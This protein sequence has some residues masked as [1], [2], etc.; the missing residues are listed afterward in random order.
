MSRLIITIIL[1]LVL[2]LPDSASSLTFI[3]GPV[4][5]G[6]WAQTWQ[7]SIPPTQIDRIE[8]FIVAGTADFEAPGLRNFSNG[9]V[10]GSLV[11]PDQAI[12]QGPV[13]SSIFTFQAIYTTKP[14]VP[15]TEDFYGYTDG[16]LDE[17]SRWR[18]DGCNWH[19]EALPVPLPT[20]MLLLGS[21]LV[22]LGVWRFRAC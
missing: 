19:Q 8:T 2:S 12:A 13:T 11:D 15:F 18:W 9:W 7:W 14:C 6:S 1:S 4:E 3:G 20:S 22:G 5:V 10:N 17:A 21:G 16:R